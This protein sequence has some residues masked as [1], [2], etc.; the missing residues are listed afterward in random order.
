MIPSFLIEIIYWKLKT[1]KRQVVSFL[2]KTKDKVFQFKTKPILQMPVQDTKSSLKILV[3][4]AQLSV[5]FA[6]SWS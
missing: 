6:I 3:A 2:L 1:S 4:N 5:A